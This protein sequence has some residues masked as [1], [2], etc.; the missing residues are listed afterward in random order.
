MMHAGGLGGF[1]SSTISMHVQ[2]AIQ[3]LSKVIGNRSKG[4]WGGGSYLLS[5]A[6]TV[7]GCNPRQRAE[8]RPDWQAKNTQINRT[9]KGK[10]LL[11]GF[12]KIFIST[13]IQFIKLKI[14]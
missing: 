4:S 6:M 11:D 10:E 14:P 8:N 1:C 7:N 2:T 5:L 13:K 12:G 9:K 3:Y